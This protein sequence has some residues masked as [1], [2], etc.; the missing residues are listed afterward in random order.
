MLEDLVVAVDLSGGSV[1]A[2]I[3]VREYVLKHPAFSRITSMLK[4]YR[5]IGGG[6]KRSYIR[7]FPR[8]YMKLKPYLEVVKIYTY[9]RDT[10]NQVNELLHE[11]CPSVAIV[12]D[13][14]F[15]T[16]TYPKKVQ[17][18]KVSKDYLKRLVNLADNL[19]NY[20]RM[21]LKNNPERFQE[22]LKNFEK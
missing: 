2:V 17:E 22:E 5:E 10:I 1:I 15:N 6:K 21:L 7:A 3:G 4:Y 8:R 9:S 20:F 11:T 18:G 12:D 19:A 13:R 16:I 14:I